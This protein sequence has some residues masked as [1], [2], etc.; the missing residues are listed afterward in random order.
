MRRE[1]SDEGAQGGDVIFL[2]VVAGEKAIAFGEAFQAGAPEGLGFFRDETLPEN[3]GAGAGFRTI[4]R[5]AEGEMNA[6]EGAENFGG[7]EIVNALGVAFVIAAAHEFLH[8]GELLFFAEV[9]DFG[10]ALAVLAGFGFLEEAPGEKFGAVDFGI[11]GNDFL[12]P[13]IACGEK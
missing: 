11:F 13:R 2:N 10:K 12:I 8:E 6:G 9:R 5:E 4:A 3:D 1:I 7:V